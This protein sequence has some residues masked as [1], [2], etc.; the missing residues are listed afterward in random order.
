LSDEEFRNFSRARQR[1]NALSTHGEA[2]VM[3]VNH[4]LSMLLLGTAF[5]C[6][7]NRSTPPAASPQTEFR[8]TATIKDIMDSLVDPSADEIWESVA[9]VVD[10]SGVHDKYPRTDDEWKAVRRDA[11]RL[12]EAT[13]LLQ[14]PGRLV[15]KHGEKSENPGIELEPEEMEKLIN[16]DRATFHKRAQ[17]LH[18]SVMATFKAIEAKDKDALLASGAAI[19]EACEKCHMTYWYPNEAKPVAEQRAQ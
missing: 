2:G 10:A 17:G 1:E 7:S 16:D 14:M 4:F 19:D 13:N 9:T 15:A 3:K 8:T 18:D 11:I 6:S 5:A 12:L